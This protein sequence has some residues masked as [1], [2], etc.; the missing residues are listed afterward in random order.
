MP[1]VKTVSGQMEAMVLKSRLE[2]E[3]IPVHLSYESTGP[4]YGFSSTNL[5]KVHIMVP[6]PFERAARIICGTES[7]DNFDPENPEDSGDA[8]A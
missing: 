1:V 3:H 2:A 7:G 6:S 8:A 4:L 5:G